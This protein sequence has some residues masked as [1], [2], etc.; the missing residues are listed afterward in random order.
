MMRIHFWG[1]RGSLPVATEGAVIR[2]KLKRALVKA[3]GRR[4]D[5]EAQ[6][7]A[8]I[9]S[10][11]EFPLR[12]SYGG[13]SSCVEIIGG[14]HYTLCDMGSGLRCFGEHMMRQHGPAQ[15]QLYNFFMSHAHWDHIMGLPFFPPAYIPGNTIRIHGGH[16]PELLEEALRRQ[17]SSPCFPVQWAQLRATIEFIHLDTERWYDIDGLRVKAKLQPHPGD[18]FGYRFEKAGRAAIYSTDGEHQLKSAS[19]TA[20]M[21]E[22][23]RNADLV[24]FD[25][26]YSLNEMIDAKQ[27]WGHSSNVIGVD[28]CLQAQVKHYC[29]FHHDPVCGDDML[30]SVLGETQRYAEIAGEQT[31]LIVSTAYD[32]LVIDV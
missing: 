29:M 6:L 1:T 30:H 25:A 28:L 19:D 9:D 31:K 26:M 13:N 16:A 20:A 23:Y 18:S 5:N 2:D 24:I 22:F 4:F 17:H 14:D 21:V 3:G 15:P 8:F 32:G 10:E 27:D 12:H 7:D 11:L